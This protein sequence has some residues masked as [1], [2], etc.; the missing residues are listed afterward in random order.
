[1]DTLP[2][3][4]CLV[5]QLGL[6]TFPEAMEF[7]HKL[8]K[9]VSDEQIDNIV[10]IFEHPPTITTGR[11]GNAD[12]ILIPSGE[13]EKK[14]ISVYTSDRGGETTFNC[15]GQLVLHPIINLRYRRAR[16]YINDLE[17]TA[18][19]VLLDY[20]LAAE[21]ESQHP[22]IWV[23]NKQIVAIGLRI[24][25]GISMH[26]LSLNVNPD[27]A[28]F[29]FINLCGLPGR[30]AT[31]MEHE[32]KHNVCIAEINQKLLASFSS[33]FQVDLSPISKEQLQIRCFTSQAP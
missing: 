28:S 11:F 12:N 30:S 3:G 6:I 32:L 33:V 17:E 24:S 16:A 20:G 1:M 18:L 26:G 15:P 22:G 31:S 19:R 9:L 8:L 21:R 27:L 25:R 23:H 14:G 7:E 5:C 29:K 13:L 10:L 4:H 2:K